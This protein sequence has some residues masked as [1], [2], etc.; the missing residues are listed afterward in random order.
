M[1]DGQ[2]HPQNQNLTHKGKS[3]SLKSSLTLLT[4]WPPTL[5]GHYRGWRDAS[6]SDGTS[7]VSLSNA[8]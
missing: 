3:Y 4:L 2:L 6:D 7:A 5:G 1:R 8:G